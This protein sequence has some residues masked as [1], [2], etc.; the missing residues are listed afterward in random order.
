MPPSVP[1]TPS[2]RA[3]CGAP[4]SPSLFPRRGKRGRGVGVTGLAKLWRPG[5]CVLPE[6]SYSYCLPGRALVFTH[7]LRLDTG[8]PNL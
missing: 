5:D 8:G 7:Y 6:L 1:N 2:P 4:F 3:A